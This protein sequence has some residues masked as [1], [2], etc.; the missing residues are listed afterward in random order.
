MKVIGPRKVEDVVNELFDDYK[1]TLDEF[2]K[3]R[4][5]PGKSDSVISGF[6]A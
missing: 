3:D 5:G 4:G 6:R 2:T 1:E